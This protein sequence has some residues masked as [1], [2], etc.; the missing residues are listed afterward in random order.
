M[1]SNKV[2]KRWAI[3]P[4]PKIPNQTLYIQIEMVLGMIL[5]SAIKAC[6]SAIIFGCNSPWQPITQICVPKITLCMKNV[7][8]QPPVYE[9]RKKPCSVQS[10]PVWVMRYMEYRPVNH[11]AENNISNFE[12][13]SRKL[14]H[15]SFLKETIFL[16]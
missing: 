9:R 2:S 16:L 8:G 12:K 11:K 10:I 3:W 7:L 14:Y 4:F 6:L 5:Q 15:L 1:T 13:Q